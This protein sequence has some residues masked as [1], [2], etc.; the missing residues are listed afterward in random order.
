MNEMISDKQSADFPTEFCENMGMDHILF[1]FFFI[2]ILKMLYILKAYVFRK[3]NNF[4]LINN[5][6]LL[7]SLIH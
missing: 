3:A 4:N 7:L 1:I 5:N 2:L 6:T